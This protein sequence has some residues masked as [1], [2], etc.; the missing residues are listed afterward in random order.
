MFYAAERW[1]LLA[2]E[3]LR[4]GFGSDIT[5]FYLGRAA[6]GLGKIEAAKNDYAL[7]QASKTHCDSVVN[8]CDGLDITT[9]ISHASAL[10]KV[11][12]HQRR[13]KRPFWLLL[14]N[15]WNQP[16]Y[17]SIRHLLSALRIKMQLPSVQKR[18]LNLL[19]PRLQSLQNE[20]HR[21][22][23]RRGTG[24][25]HQLRI[26]PLRPRCSFRSILIEGL[27]NSCQQCHGGCRRRLRAP[28]YVYGSNRFQHQG[29]SSSAPKLVCCPGNGDGFRFVAL[30]LT[31][32]VRTAEVR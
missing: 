17:L 1:T 7:G 5:Y 21:N 11:K 4:I 3:V 19:Q 6:E 8:N 9:N 23:R 31:A 24:W 18:L 14:C 15:T 22:S 20:A 28:G 32:L 27:R 10:L 12:L 16:P 13:K 26:L 29:W 2:D 30:V 25:A